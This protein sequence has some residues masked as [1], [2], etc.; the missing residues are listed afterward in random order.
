MKVTQS[1]PTL[2]DPMD[3]PWNSPGKNTG[4]GSFQARIDPRCPALHTDSLPSESPG[5][6]IVFSNISV[7]SIQQPCV[8]QWAGVVSIRGLGTWKPDKLASHLELNLGL[9]L[10]D[11]GLLFF[12][13]PHCLSNPFLLGSWMTL[14]LICVR[15]LSYFGCVQFFVTPW[16]ITLQAPLSMGF[17]SQECWSGLPCPPPGDLSNPGI[18][19]VSLTSP[20]LAGGFFTISA[21]CSTRPGTRRVSESRNCCQYYFLKSEVFLSSPDA[22]STV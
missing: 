3:C 8:I 9:R 14:G 10:S 17:S 12:H 16:T 15:V 11:S 2:C 5:K 6:P 4:V 13:N 20:A 19:P 7:K 1:H 21:T 22:H 18:E